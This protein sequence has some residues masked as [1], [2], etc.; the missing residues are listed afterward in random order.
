MVETAQQIANIISQVGF[1]IAMATALLY[2]VYIL[3]KSHKEE[4]NNWIE[5]ITKNTDAV[6][7]LV[8]LVKEMKKN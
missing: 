8:E 6:N 5:V 7:T 3:S 4:S 2:V 1:P